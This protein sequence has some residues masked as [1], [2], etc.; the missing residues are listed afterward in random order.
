MSKLEELKRKRDDL[1]AEAEAIK[2]RIIALPESEQAL[3]EELWHQEL[4]IA[5]QLEALEDEIVKAV[6][7][8]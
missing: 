1:R 7:Y 3:M 5:N 2:S 4:Q 6:V 8:K